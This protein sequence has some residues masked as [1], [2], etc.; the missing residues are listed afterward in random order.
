[1]SVLTICQNAMDRI[2]LPRPASLI[3]ATDSAARQLLALANQEGIELSRR[4]PWQA[5][6]K[7]HTFSTV[8]STVAYDL[9]TDFGRIVEGSLW[10]RTQDRRIVGPIGAQAWQR[11]QAETTSGTWQAVYIRGGSMRFTPTPSAAETIAYEYVSRY[12]CRGS[13]HAITAPTQA[14]WLVD[15][16]ETMLDA[17]AMTLGV[18]WRFLKARGLDYGEIFRSYE[19]TVA[20][21]CA[22]DGGQRI[23][24]LSDV[25][26]DLPEPYIA[27][28]NWSLS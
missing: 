6:V 3:G 2:G 14:E 9:P 22:N 10:N 24:D 11:T 15:T 19:E 5:I 1:M 12:W 27:D 28:G 26:A 18:Q 7:E 21:L 17:E 16:D 23:I 8:S 25:P 4:F 13:D 20:M